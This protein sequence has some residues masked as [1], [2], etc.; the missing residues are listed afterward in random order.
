[1]GE[2][3]PPSILWC[4]YMCIHEH[5]SHCSVWA[6]TFWHCAM[7][8]ILHCTNCTSVVKCL[9]WFLPP[10]CFTIFW[11][12]Q[13]AW[14]PLSDS[15][16]QYMASEWSS[17]PGLQR[18]AH[19]KWEG[20][21]SPSDFLRSPQEELNHPRTTKDEMKRSW[22]LMSGQLGWPP[23]STHLILEGSQFHCF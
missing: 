11:M 21:N 18:A 7:H 6:V 3:P 5:R 20:V 22:K 19:R 8:S 10:T 23:G 15:S 9:A 16:L 13:W 1:M 12:K 2:S 17:Q 4:S 14:P